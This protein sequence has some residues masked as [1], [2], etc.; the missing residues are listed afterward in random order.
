MTSLS[1]FVNRPKQTVEEWC[2]ENGVRMTVSRIT[3]R[4]DRVASDWDKKAS[5][6]LCE[7]HAADSTLATYYSQGSGHTFYKH[8]QTHVKTPTISDV[9]GCLLMDA[10]EFVDSAPSFEEWAGNY[11]YDTDSISALRIYES[12]KEM[13]A[14]LDKFLPCKLAGAY[15]SI[16]M[17]SI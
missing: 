10:S 16:D 13:A 9:L 15:D 14:K 6:W 5:H 8:G 17:D 7:F 4:P 3:S 11:G 12:C 1:D 2:K